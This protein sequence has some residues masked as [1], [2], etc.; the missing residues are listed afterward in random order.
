VLFTH[1]SSSESL[2]PGAWRLAHVSHPFAG[3]RKARPKLITE[4][5]RAA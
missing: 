1:K 4:R 2:V 3:R 5:A